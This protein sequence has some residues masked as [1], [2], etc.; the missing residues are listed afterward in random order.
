MGVFAD[1]V[2]QMAEMDLFQLFFPWLLVFAVTY[3][4]LE[5]NQVF[6]EEAQV[7]GVI[8]M[9]IAFMAV[10][11][12]LLF[13]PAG[14]YANFAAALSF[15]IFALVGTM[16]FLGVTGY[17]LSEMA[18]DKGPVFW[19]AMIMAAIAI[20][21]VIGANLNVEAIVGTPSSSLLQELV[22]PVIV[23]LFL[24]VVVWITVAESGGGE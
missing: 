4:V 14:L 7:N 1:V 11:G 20:V 23:L 13:I 21:G 17:D 10:I 5:K 8:A 16:I 22:M 15:G 6:S 9:S 2:R 18:D 3:G 24:I 19:G 12:S